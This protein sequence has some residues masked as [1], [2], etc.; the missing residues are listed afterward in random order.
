MPTKWLFCK[1]N[2]NHDQI[3]MPLLY[4]EV[5]HLEGSTPHSL[6]GDFHPSP[7]VTVFLF[8]VFEDE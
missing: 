5:M 1:V 6:P 7:M 8:K 2:G 4:N 3:I